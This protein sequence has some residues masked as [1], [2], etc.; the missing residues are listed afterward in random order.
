MT[1]CS[2]APS[3]IMSRSDSQK[4]VTEKAVQLQAPETKSKPS[5]PEVT[6]PNTKE[7]Q[8]MGTQDAEIPSGTLAVSAKQIATMVPFKIRSIR[9][10]D[11]SGRMPRGY[12][13]GGKKVW[14]ISDL[15]QWV[16]LGFPDR[17]KFEEL[18][19][20]AAK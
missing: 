10:M 14:R 4:A 17:E 13:V 19:K 15:E 11:A 1:N 16:V 6:E 2:N 9:R 20:N 7:T 18:T 3:A 8:T 5:N 12:I